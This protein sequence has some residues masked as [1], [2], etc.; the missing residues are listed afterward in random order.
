M[1]SI[2]ILIP[3]KTEEFFKICGKFKVIKDIHVNENEPILLV[4]PKIFEELI[5]KNLI[6][7]EPEGV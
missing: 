7:V 5:K 2:C 3:K 4:S 1:S 6:K